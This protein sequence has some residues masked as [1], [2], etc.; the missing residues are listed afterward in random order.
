M[1]TLDSVALY[2]STLNFKAFL[3]VAL[4]SCC[5]IIAASHAPAKT[6]MSAANTDRNTLLGFTL[7]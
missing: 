1:S 5:K 3:N 2:V 6:N 4:R 7:F